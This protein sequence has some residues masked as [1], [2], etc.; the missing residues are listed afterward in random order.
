MHNIKI[1]NSDQ[2]TIPLGHV[3]DLYPD[4]DATA[5]RK[6]N[7]Y[8]FCRDIDNIMPYETYPNSKY[9]FVLNPSDDKGI[10]FVSHLFRPMDNHLRIFPHLHDLESN[11]ADFIRET[12]K[13]LAYFGKLHWEIVDCTLRDARV[14]ETLQI[15]W[16]VR[17]PGRVN[18]A[19]KF[20]R[21]PIPRS[22]QASVGKTYVNIPSAK[23]WSIE[24]PPRFGGPERQKQIIETLAA[25]SDSMPKV[26]SDAWNRG[27]PNPQFDI[28]KYSH[29]QFVQ[30]AKLMQTWSWLFNQWQEGE[31]TEYYWVYRQLQFYASLAALREHILMSMNELLRHLE[32]PY[33][34][35]LEGLPHE[36]QITARI[37]DLKQRRISFKDALNFV[38]QTDLP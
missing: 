18:R 30:I 35:G 21:Q 11:I 14:E 9:H 1:E 3:P 31:T 22:V 19:G 32:I 33:H 23:I 5:I 10:A 7:V 16:A 15:K 29:N 20:Y 4:K 2:I 6:L 36:A 27:N 37:D 24:I 38:Y 28:K 17:I 13:N 26:M 12:G 34:I 25:L 8:I